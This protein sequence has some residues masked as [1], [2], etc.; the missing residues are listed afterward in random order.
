MLEEVGLNRREILITNSVKC[1]PPNNRKPTTAERKACKPYLEKELAAVKPD[2]V[3]AMGNAAM[4]TMLGTSGIMSKANAVYPSK[5]GVDVLPVVHPAFVLRDPTHH[6]FMKS[7]L[8]L[9]K[10]VLDGVNKPPETKVKLVRTRKGLDYLLSELTNCT[11]PIVLDIESGTPTGRKDGGLEPWAPDWRL[12]TISFSWKEGESWV[13]PLEHPEQ[14]W[15]EHIEGGYNE[16]IYEALDKILSTKRIVGH[17]VKF[18]LV[19]LRWRGVRAKAHFDT[20]VAAHLLD[21]NRASKSLKALAR[22]YLGAEAYEDAINRE[23]ILQ[24][25]LEKIALYN[26]RDTDYT[27]RLYHLFRNE[28]LKPENKRLLRIFM[29]LSM[30]TVNALTDVETRGFPVD[31]GRLKHRNGL[32][33]EK[34]AELSAEMLAYVPDADKDKANWNRSN[35]L[36]DFLFKTLD[37]PV[38]DV[39]PTDKPSMNRDCLLEIRGQHPVIPL[40]LEYRKWKK[41]ESTYTRPWIEKIKRVGK[42]RLYPTYNVTGTVT[43]RLSSNFQQVP[44]DNFI[45]GIIGAKK[46]WTLIE[47]DFSQIELRIA[48]MVSGEPTMSRIYREG[49]DIHL[50]MAT[51]ITGKPADQVTKEERSRAKPVNFGFL[52]GMGWRNYVPYALSNYDQE[53]TDEQ[54]QHYR[55][56]FFLRF[57]RLKDWHD[58][59]RRLVGA[60]GYVDS[61]IGRRRR[62]P[63][64]ASSDKE[65]VAEA[66]RQAINSPVQG[67]ASDLTLLAITLLE[68]SDLYFFHGFQILGQVHDSIL[69]EGPE[70]NAKQ[71]ARYIEGVMNGL[72]PVVRR[73]FGYAPPVPIVADVKVHKHWGGE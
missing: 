25:P 60:L 48:A 71:A 39:T 15:S 17:N 21:E 47:A 72:A 58:R 1:R 66:E 50:D 57:P 45:R 41:W 67:F 24:E 5:M 9:A 33:E 28:L 43:G 54:A 59:Q 34:L 56:M 40:L 13:L 22:Q 73:K 35:F 23:K 16:D 68:N 30:P 49:G 18:D 12:A 31:L 53:V 42:G 3:I 19:G 32:I 44:R 14:D 51:A 69:F 27:L 20:I 7:G 11:D 6:D 8:L 52:Y 26:G 37:L 70:K 38:V 10:R 29:L 61:P 55:S 65:K 64:I 46:G 2:L 36:E 62:L 4:Q 63:A